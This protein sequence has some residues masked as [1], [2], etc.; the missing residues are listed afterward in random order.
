MS[1]S[2]TRPSSSHKNMSDSDVLAPT[3]DPESWPTPETATT[4]DRRKSTSLEKPESRPAESKSHRGRWDTMPFVPTVVFNTP[5]PS[6]A[7]RGGRGGGRG[8]D[9]VGR[10]NAHANGSSEKPDVVGAMGPPPPPK[11]GEQERGR[12]PDSSRGGRATSLPTQSRRDESGSIQSSESRKP[13]E[14]LN[15]VTIGQSQPKAPKVEPTTPPAPTETIAAVDTSAMDASLS[16]AHLASNASASAEADA[17]NSQTARATNNESHAHPATEEM[18]HS[19]QADWSR[20]GYHSARTVSDGPKDKP[21]TK[22][23][24]LPRER[25][26]Y[27]RD[28]WRD[29]EQDRDVPWDNRSRRDSRSERGRGS[30][31]GRGSRDSYGS[32]GVSG[33][34]FTAPLPQQ[35]FTSAKNSYSDN[36]HRQ[37][38]QPY[39]ALQTGQGNRNNPRSQS[40]P[41]TNGYVQYPMGVPG[42]ISPV[43]PMQ[44]DPMMY[45]YGQYPSIISPTYNNTPLNQ[46]AQYS[47]VVSQLEYYFSVNNLCRDMFLRKHMDSQGWVLLDVIANFPRMK[48]LNQDEDVLKYACSQSATIDYLPGQN[49]QPD[50]IR[51]KHDY[52]KFVLNPQL[53]VPEAQNDGPSAD[54]HDIPNTALAGYPAWSDPN[55]N[56]ISQSRLQQ[57][58]E[59][60]FEAPAS[61]SPMEQNDPPNLDGV[62]TKAFQISDRAMASATG[63]HAVPVT[64]G[65]FGQAN[66]FDSVPH[67]NGNGPASSVNG[68][69]TGTDVFRDAGEDAFPDQQIADLKIVSRKSDSLSP[70]SQPPFISLTDR[71]FSNGSVD[72]VSQLLGQSHQRN[73]LAASGLRGG[74]GSPQQ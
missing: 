60:T 21:Y 25:S 26:E 59:N 70:T 73:A 33:Q 11:S 62:T 56:L 50:R 41:T 51:R 5:I 19:S 43:S 71:T 29:R 61:G 2:S 7:R 20:G 23:R 57:W 63:Q 8:R 4:D 74:S 12:K 58:S 31:R 38:S 35:P 36:R 6:S 47:M 16:D 39:S 72:S 55:S 49:G 18:W 37:S 44:A 24:D 66:D 64:F 32:H 9:G 45:A 17:S 68:A 14:T 42:M 10:G 48:Q 40:I 65:S 46:F 69:N 15:Q 30:Y 52:S 22:S 34:S 53:R 27:A 28:S 13:V 3:E 54:T 1:M 67:V